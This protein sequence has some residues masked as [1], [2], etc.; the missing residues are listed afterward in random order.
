MHPRG[1]DQRVG[2]YGAGQFA[3]FRPP[4]SRIEHLRGRP[5]PRKIVQKFVSGGAY[6]RQ[7]L[8]GKRH[9]QRISS[10]GLNKDRIAANLID[11][12]LLV[13]RGNHLTCSGRIKAGIQQ[14][15]LIATRE[16]RQP[17]NSKKNTDGRSNDDHPFAK[18][19]RG[20]D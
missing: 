1:L 19:Q 5:E 9:P 6:R 20:P 17:Q 3:L 4:V 12:S 7:T 11:D 8:A 14:R 10:T 2:E 13:Q 18:I 16:P 15:H